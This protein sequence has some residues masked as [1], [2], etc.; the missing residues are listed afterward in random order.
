MPAQETFFDSLILQ[1][2]DS[3]GLTEHLLQMRVWVG[4]LLGR[5]SGAWLARSP[6]LS[7]GSGLLW[8]EDACLGSL[9]WRGPSC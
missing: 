9:D 1:S 8:W 2:T 6:A 3:S 7:R 4:L 5:F